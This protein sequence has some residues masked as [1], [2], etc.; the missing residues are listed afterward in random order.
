MRVLLAS[1]FLGPGLVET[2]HSHPFGLA[3]YTYGAGGVP[4]AADSGMNRQ[5]WGYTTGSVTAWLEEHLPEGGSVYVCD[6]THQAIDMLHRDGQ[7][8]R[9]IRASGDLASADYVLV[10]HEHHF[11]EVEFQA[12]VAF[13]TRA[14]AHVLTHDGVP[15][16]SIYENPRRRRGRR[17]DGAGP[18]AR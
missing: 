8:R 12:W 7:L 9:N 4:G 2:A 13:D 5:F 3:H 1:V 6:T 16:I 11:A 15:I 14:P 10:H 17:G 18:G